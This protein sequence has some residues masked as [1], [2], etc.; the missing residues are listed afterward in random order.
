MGF[1]DDHIN[2][3]SARAEQTQLVALLRSE[4]P[5]MQKLAACKRLA[6]IG[7]KEAVPALA[8]LLLDE[9]L[10][11]AA[12][13]ALEAIPDP[14]AGAALR[15]AL[16]K[17]QGQVLVGVINS[18]GMR[19]DAEAVA[20][21]SEY[22][23]AEA[24]S[25][26]SREVVDAAARALGRMATPTAVQRLTEALKS[27]D[28]TVRVAAGHGGLLAADT[29]AAQGN[30]RQALA[31]Y[32]A[33]RT[34]DVGQSARL[35]ATRGAILLRGRDGLALLAAELRS[36]DRRRFAMAL[37][38]S[39]ELTAPQTTATLLQQLSQL[40]P[41]R[42]ALVLGVL[43]D[44]GD[45]SAW[46]ALRR[47]VSSEHLAVRVAAIRALAGLQ[48]PTA[49]PLLFE[50]AKQ[51]SEKGES[52]VANAALASLT[53]I[54]SAE[55]DAALVRTL[56]QAGGAFRLLLIELA[57]RR[58][59][60]AA[61]PG[62]LR[63]MNDSDQTVRAAALRALGQTIDAHRLHH[64]TDRLL[65]PRDDQDEA[66]VRQ[67]LQTACSRL[68]DKQR[69][70]Q[71]LAACYGRAKPATKRFL[72]DLLGVVGGPTALDVVARAA[73]DADPAIQDTA[74]RVLGQWMSPDA[75]PTL[76]R[77]AKTSPNNKFRVRCLRGYI[78]LIRQFDIPDARRVS[79]CREAL[80]AATRVDEKRL[81]L[82]A[83]SRVASTEALTL[84]TEQ[85]KQPALREPASEAALVIA[86]QIVSEH[87]EA[88]AAAMQQVLE[89]TRNAD[90]S[91]RARK[92]LERSHAGARR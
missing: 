56:S 22:L 37:Q 38:V 8:P 54:D 16:P 55:V 2:E 43:G 26:S 68:P 75:A 12:R 71:Q 30:S 48:V 80:A 25:Q 21:V 90:R 23:S 41:A 86:E 61:L 40:S 46:P 92:L 47:A 53:E 19:R 3:Q 89:A 9:K 82:A 58:R 6:A 65:A 59:T 74:T 91:Q 72:L 34:A 24:V 62:L 44:R 42:Q 66:A 14:Q 52:E 64:L 51:S 39:R 69:V 73:F 70:A 20:A 79:M 81:A 83:L 11:H 67:A 78:R 32:D 17:L 15:A 88:V 87:P 84:A 85:L 28:E 60:T 63:A 5:Y 13:I 35:A 45:R 18:I 77:V 33:I 36:A 29:L 50:V 10:S 31:L 1:A 7:D 49:I 57:G 4:A 27:G 76:L